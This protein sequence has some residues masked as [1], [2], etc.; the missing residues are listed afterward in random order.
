[1]RRANRDVGRLVVGAD[2][3]ERISLS[4]PFH[5]C[6]QREYKRAR[7]LQAI[8]TTSNLQERAHRRCLRV[9]DATDVTHPLPE[10]HKTTT[11]HPR[12]IHQS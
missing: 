4:R 2:T 8:H 6:L 10:N 3:D 7:C 5:D 9:A 1:M 11:S 12:A